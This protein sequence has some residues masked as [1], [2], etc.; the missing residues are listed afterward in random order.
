MAKTTSAFDRE[1][2]ALIKVILVL[3]YFVIVFWAVN[4]IRGYWGLSISVDYSSI[5]AALLVLA[6]ILAK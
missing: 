3:V 1:T 2:S 5:A 6:V 4:A